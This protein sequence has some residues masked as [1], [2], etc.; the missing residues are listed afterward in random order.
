[1]DT[2]AF[3]TAEPSGARSSGRRNRRA[4]IVRALRE[5][6]SAS[7]AELA[8]GL[9][10]HPNTIRFHLSGLEGDGEVVREQRPAYSPGR[11]ELRFRL[12]PAAE[13]PTERADLL[14]RILLSRIAAA[15]DP[16]AE[17]EAAGRQWG[18]TEA[19]S[20]TGAYAEAV[21]DL[22]SMLEEAGFAPARRGGNQIDL[23]NCP[24]RQFLGTHGRLVCSIHRGMM[25]GFLDAVGTPSAVESLTPFA[26]A[27]C[28]RTRLQTG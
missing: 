8:E 22:V 19:Q 7:V 5:H 3:P 11:P 25:A 23:L 4:E 13:P 24:L 16:T 27:T 21:D 20:R 1:M 12:S 10:V 18:S 9:G 17:A 15:E 2:E 14:G 28:C 26:T 6:T